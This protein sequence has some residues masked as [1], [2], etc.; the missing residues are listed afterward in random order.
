MMGVLGVM[1]RVLSA[2][3][4]M[5]SFWGGAILPVWLDEVDFLLITSLKPSSGQ[6]NISPTIS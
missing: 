4:P 2:W 5:L 1:S 3:K 6:E